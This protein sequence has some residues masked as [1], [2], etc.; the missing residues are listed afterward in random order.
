MTIKN[1]RLKTSKFKTQ[2][3]EAGEPGSPE[4]ICL[5]YPMSEGR[6]VE[7]HM[8]KAE[9]R[10]SLTGGRNKMEGLRSKV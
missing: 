5:H 2:K 1:N 7:R 8:P 6:R 9:V 3:S 10:C 4:T